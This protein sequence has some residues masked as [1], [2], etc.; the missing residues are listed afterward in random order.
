MRPLRSRFVAHRDENHLNLR[1]EPLTELR[2]EKAQQGVVCRLRKAAILTEER[3]DEFENRLGLGHCK[4]PFPRTGPSEGPRLSR[5][6]VFN[7]LCFH[8]ILPGAEAPCF[9]YGEE[10]P[11][12]SLLLTPFIL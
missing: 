2:R 5:D 6:L 1:G 9:S 11:G 3:D 7:Q 12:F 4:P 10:A 8:R